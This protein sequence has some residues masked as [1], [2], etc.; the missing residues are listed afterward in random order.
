M[1]SSDGSLISASVAPHS[2]RNLSVGDVCL[3]IY[4]FLSSVS[5]K[6]MTT[7]LVFLQGWC[8][9]VCEC[10]CVSVSV[11]VCVCVCVCV[12]CECAYLLL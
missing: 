8:V 10:V 3:L 4:H 9:C 2:G 11:S 6:P 1:F 12:A 7:M 5:I